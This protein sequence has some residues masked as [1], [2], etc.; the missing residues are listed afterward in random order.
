MIARAMMAV[1]ALAAFAPAAAAAEGRYSVRNEVG[2][3]FTCGL[4]RENRSVI[5]RFLLRP[6]D[7][8]RQTSPD[9]GT[10]ILLCDAY[11]ITPQYPMREGV[12]YRLIEDERTGL[13]VLQPLPR[14]GRAAPEAAAAA[15]H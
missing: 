15:P 1:A 10:R 5:D 13:I 6:G 14:G 8:W 7:E 11:M 4:K 3:T 12:A 2:R 9:D